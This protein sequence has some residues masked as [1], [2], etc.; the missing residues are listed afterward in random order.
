MVNQRL[1]TGL[2]IHRWCPRPPFREVEGD[3][4]RLLVQD[5]A[6]ETGPKTRPM[7]NSCWRYR[8]LQ[9]RAE[10][11]LLRRAASEFGELVWATGCKC[12]ADLAEETVSVADGAAWV[13]KWVAQQYHPDRAQVVDRYRAVAYLRTLAEQAIGERKPLRG[14]GARRPQKTYG[15]GTLTICL[16]R[17]KTGK[18]TAKQVLQPGTPSVLPKQ[19]PANRLRLSSPG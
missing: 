15:K 7:T 8:R 4:S 17:A 13:W 19:S 2:W 18:R 11:L 10:E 16:Q 3:E 14:S 12:G 6:Y 9:G 5:S 1:E